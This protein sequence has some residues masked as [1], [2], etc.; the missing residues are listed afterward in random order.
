E[1]T[2]TA[3]VSDDYDATLSQPASLALISRAAFVV[4]PLS[5]TAVE[6]GSVT[7]SAAVTGTAPITF[8]WRKGST[9]ITSGI[10]YTNPIQGY[11]SLTLTNLQLSDALTNYNVVVSNL[12][13]FA[14]GGPQNGVS[15]NATLTV[16]ADTDRDGIPDILE[17]LNG[18]A[19]NDGDGMS[20]AAEYF[21][22][23]DYSDPDSS[24]KLTITPGVPGTLSFLAVSNATYPVQYTDTLGTGG[25]LKLTDVLARASTRIESFPVPGNATNRCYRVLTPLQR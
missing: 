12:L 25:W 2:Y 16:L 20:N 14:T 18:A 11:S 15:S 21:A 7:F 8:R 23:T 5:Q 22:G 3:A 6:G 24:L 10:L 4:H 9:N 13:G 17:P 19:D 1:G